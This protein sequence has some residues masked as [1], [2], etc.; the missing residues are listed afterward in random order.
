[1]YLLEATFQK[2]SIFVS[3]NNIDEI[4]NSVASSKAQT[5]NISRSNKIFNS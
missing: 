5:L 3:N 4:I 2:D 1:M